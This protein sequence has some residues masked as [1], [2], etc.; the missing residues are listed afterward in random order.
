M[1]GKQNNRRLTRAT[2]GGAA[3][4]LGVGLL[5]LGL[6][7]TQ[8]ANA[9]GVGAGL[10]ITTDDLAFILEQIQIAEAHATKP[11]A[12]A[13]QIVAPTSVLNCGVSPCLSDPTLPHGLR[14]VSGRGNNLLVNDVP[15]TPMQPAVAGDLGAA[16][17]PFPRFGPANWRATEAGTMLGVPAAPTTYQNRA[18]SVQDAQPRTISN[19]VA[20][21]N[22]TTNAAAD[23]AAGGAALDV[24]V[25]AQTP[26][27]NNPG[28]T[29][30]ILNV[31]PGGQPGVGQPVAAPTSG[32]FTLFGQFFD[33]GLDL[34]GKTG[35]QVVVIPLDA[36]DPLLALNPGAPNFMVANRTVV[37]GNLDGVNST[38]PW[39]DQNQTYGS[40]ASKQVFMR[41]FNLV[42]KDHDT[43][44]GTPAKS[45]PEDT[46]K[47][48]DDAASLGYIANWTETKAQAAA[49]LGISLVDT[50]VTNVPLLLTD[51]YGNFLPGPGGFPQV[52]FP[53]NTVVEGDPTAPISIAGAVRTGHSFLDDIAHAAVPDGS[54]DAALLGQHFIT[55]DG[56]GNENI[57]LTAMHTMFHA[58]HNRLVDDITGI[59]AT[60]PALDAGFNAGTGTAG[61]WTR[62][63]RL[64]QAARFVNEMEYQ[65]AVFEEFGR[66]FSPALRPFAAYDPTLQPD[67]SAEFAH[68]VYRFGHSMLRENVVRT[69]ANGADDSLR[70]LDAFLNP[71]AFQAGYANAAAAAG[72]IARGMNNQRS[73][74][75]DEFVTS[76]LR[77]SLLGL[78]LDLPALNIARGRDTGT[79]SLNQTRVAMG[80][81]PHAS[82]SEFGAALTHPL[83]LVNFIAAYG[84][85][86]TLT[87]TGNN[88]A[89]RRAAATT[90]MLN[91]AFMDGPAALTGT[92]R[93]D[94]WMGGLAERRN[95]LA[96]ELLGP[97]FN[98][99]FQITLENLQD[100]DRFYYLDRLAGLNLL[101]SIEGNTLSEMFVRNTDADVLPA[102][103]FNVPSLTVDLRIQG[104]G[105]AAFPNTGGDGTLSESP[106]NV[107][108]ATRNVTYANGLLN[109]TVGGTSGNDRIRTSGGGDTV[110]GNEGDDWIHGD[111]GADV[112]VGG[113]GDDII[114]NTGG[115]DNMI[116][117]PGDDVFNG[118][119][120][121]DVMNGN[122]G[123]DYMLSGALGAVTLGGSG[124]ERQLGGAGADGFTGDD[125]DDWLE[126]G[127]AADAL[128][129]DTIAPFGVDINTPGEDVLIG[130]PGTGDA[131]DGGGRMDVF[132]G[133]S[134]TVGSTV[135]PQIDDYLGGL[136]FDWT[137]YF[138]SRTPNADTANFAGALPANDPGLLLDSFIDVEAL[139]GG[140]FDDTLKGD[141]RTTLAGLT[142]AISDGLP[143]G[144]VASIV[145][146]N[147][148]LGS[149]ATTGWNNGNIL[150]GGTGSDTLEGRGG[151]DLIDGDAYLT[152]QLS[153]PNGPSLTNLLP[154][155]FTPGRSEVSSLTE[156][157]GGVPTNTR[158][159]SG[160]VNPADLFAVKT[161]VANT[162]A[163]GTDVAVFAFNSTQC[164]VTNGPNAGEFNVLCPDGVDFV[165]NV[166]TFR[167]LNGPFAPASLV[168]SVLVPPQ[169]IQIS[170]NSGPTTGGTSVTITGTNLATTTG[171][172]FGGTPVPVVSTTATTVTAV[173]P[174]HALGT[175]DV[176]VNTPSGNS[177][178]AGAFTFTPP[179]LPGS[180]TITSIAPAN[181]TTAGGTSV[182]ITGTNLNGATGVTFGGQAA[183]FVGNSATQVTAT[184]P[185]HAAGVVDVVV[186]TSGP[187]TVT[188][189]NGFVYTAPAAP[190]GGGGGGA[191][192]GSSSS[193]SSAATGGGGGGSTAAVLELRPAVGPTAGGTR[194]LILGY[195]F[196]GATGATVGGKPVQSFRYI[197]AATLEIVTPSGTAGWQDVI[198]TLP[199]GNTKAGFLYQETAAGGASAPG[200]SNVAAVAPATVTTTTSAVTPAKRI[201]AAPSAPA[202]A[203]QVVT[204]KATG[205][206]KSTLVTVR[207]KIDGQWVV[208]G[209]VRTNK[210][211]VATLPPFLA[212][213]AGAYPVE[214]TGP[215][216]YKSFVKVVAS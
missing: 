136:G 148:L 92:D 183:A 24:A 181:G 17:R 114:I 176:T 44:P 96:G 22:P 66:T 14:Q 113:L 134:N 185:A 34:V 103:L 182:I 198:V 8:P 206:P 208:I 88:A 105:L 156:L 155:A 76:S 6:V 64:F 84:I 12:G 54:Y 124:N 1:T 159:L 5:P 45:V 140:A 161:I 15:T 18:A 190:G 128:T 162:G 197:D 123:N 191:T 9:A 77:N 209:K 175:V 27:L 135:I 211:G 41:D 110:R 68:A 75:I 174:L 168:G 129:G 47:L 65:H 80:L 109:I 108:P 141:D 207:A 193:S 153:V 203:G 186:T 35:A 10:S 139:S 74:E 142:P 201:G 166:E 67:I 200:A 86:N 79:P 83:S 57:G 177:T 116:G 117:G 158:V 26:G 120:D 130:G 144:D 204:V 3:L 69:R 13:G 30:Q 149:A 51:E 58:E 179:P 82:W 37:D 98:A 56:R 107:A 101:T 102:A 115:A 20:D 151:N 48:L 90:L 171:V 184:T 16:D 97:T 71:P 167:F 61:A 125:G 53:G 196:W 87:A 55:G 146:L 178:L 36:S 50:D 85:D 127:A 138:G 189:T 202:K 28:P 104:Q 160:E 72:S 199:I 213:K 49:I 111:Q 126:G 73:S 172:V 147:A 25:P 19:L 33:H 118:G 173:T 91:Q 81:A 93:I 164:Q 112:T 210:K 152:A 205:L 131:Y 95:D 150:I 121:G 212:A 100:G 78:P 43:N 214:I 133:Q 89:L 29:A 21:Q 60:N 11:G 216:G 23:A 132:V 31:P 32:M 192:G 59:L 122:T 194:A 145:G 38:T 99:V 119:P 62:Q 188:S 165:R 7:S 163:A 169:A 170:P 143:A 106:T 63:Q 2:A 40:H 39:I 180:P 195:G 157:L 46:G 187:G 42:L 4:L 215:N 154:G 52:V 137:T 94:L 70:L